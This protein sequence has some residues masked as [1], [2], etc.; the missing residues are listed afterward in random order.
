MAQHQ[1][2]VDI[3]IRPFTTWKDM[4]RVFHSPDA[5]ILLVH[6]TSGRREGTA[7]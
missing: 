6:W 4:E 1:D 3:V 7:G 5:S 2:V